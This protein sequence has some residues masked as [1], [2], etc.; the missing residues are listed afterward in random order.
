[1][2]ITVVAAYSN[3]AIYN[4]GSIVQNNGSAYQ[5]TV[6][7]WCSVGGPYELGIGWAWTSVWSGLGACDSGSSSFGGTDITNLGGSTSSQYTDSPGGE[8]DTNLVDNN[9]N[10]KYLTFH[11]LGW[12]Q[13]RTPASYYAATRYTPTSANDAAERRPAELDAARSK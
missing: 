5:C 11:A 8:G 6:G 9:T 4:T 7:G 12:A 13:Y 3:G 10:A 1:M 2:P